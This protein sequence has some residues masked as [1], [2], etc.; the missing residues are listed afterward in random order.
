[1]GSK[2]AQ[3]PSEVLPTLLCKAKSSIRPRSLPKSLC[4]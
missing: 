1:M 4:F 3:K 2:G